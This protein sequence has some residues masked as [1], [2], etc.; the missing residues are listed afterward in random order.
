MKCSFCE[1]SLVC[2]S[3]RAPFKPRAA[4]THLAVFQPEMHIV[5]PECREV[6]VCKACGYVYG[7]VESDERAAE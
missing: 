2:N 1:Q 6:L 4:D 7:E 3:C 5:C